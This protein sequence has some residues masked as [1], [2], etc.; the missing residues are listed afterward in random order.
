ML[1]ISMFYMIAGLIL[2]AAIAMVFSKNLIH[3]VLYMVAAF[4]GIAFIYVLLE[5]DYLAIV[6]ILVYVGAISVLFIFGVMLTKKDSMEK[7]NNFNRYKIFGGLVSFALFILIGRIIFISKFVSADRV[8]SS[9]TINDISNLMLN[10]FVIPFELA[11][12]LLLVSMIG[13]IVIGKGVRS[14]K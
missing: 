11:G 14:P 6:Q 1:T 3:S 5:A 9:S 8:I 12:I 2:I 10:D 13:A 4:L 7:S